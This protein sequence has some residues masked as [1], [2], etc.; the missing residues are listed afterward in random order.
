MD[1]RTMQQIDHDAW[2]EGYGHNY[3][4]GDSNA[5]ELEHMREVLRERKAREEA[6]K[7]GNEEK[8]LD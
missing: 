2:E 4:T 1:N 6:A 8:Q 3:N 5:L 7:S